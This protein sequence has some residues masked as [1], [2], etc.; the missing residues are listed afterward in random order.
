[1]KFYYFAMIAFGIMLLFTVAGIDGLGTNIRNMV[2]NNGT[3]IQ[4][5]TQYNYSATKI[6]SVGTDLTS[7]STSLWIK[8]LIALGAMVTLGSITEVRTALGGVSFDAARALRA[9]FATFLFG[10]FTSDM[11]T[12]ITKVFETDSGWIAWFLTILIL[13]FLAGF[14]Y[15]AIEYTGGTD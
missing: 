6:T 2:V 1:M 15:S 4:P 3:V 9:L 8:I 13:M 7:W 14:G 10:V 5:T 11:W 12:I